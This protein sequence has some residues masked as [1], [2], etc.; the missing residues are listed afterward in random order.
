MTGYVVS[1]GGGSITCGRCGLT[2]YNPGDVRHHYCGR[3]HVFHDDEAEL[4]ALESATELE[5]A[6]IRTIAIAKARAGEWRR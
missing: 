4:E 1:E 6:E 2:S 5:L 3:C